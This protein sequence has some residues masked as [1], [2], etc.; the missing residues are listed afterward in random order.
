MTVVT[1]RSAEC[2]DCHTQIEQEKVG[3]I[4]LPL[5]CAA[6][7]EKIAAKARDLTKSFIDTKAEHVRRNALAG[8]NVSPDV[9][10]GRLTLD[11]LAKLYAETRIN[12]GVPVYR[13][14]EIVTLVKDFVS[15]PTLLRSV[16]MKSILILE[17]DPG[18]GKTWLLEAAIGHVVREL[19]RS[20]VFVS[21]L[22]LWAQIKG[23]DDREKSEAQVM[24]DLTNCAVLGIDDIARK[25]SPTEWEIAMLLQIIDTR[26]R[27][28][29]PTLISSNYDADGLF[30]LWSDGS[31]GRKTQNVRLLCD[32]LADKKAAITISLNGRSLRRERV[33]I[34]PKGVA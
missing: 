15:I 21:P 11:N 24:A 13:Y 34:D 9:A 20:A 16:G 6:C 8:A 33:G 29:R 25:T 18:T 30:K 27:Q 4:W 31:D 3:P 23:A 19:C 32:R 22:E 26:Y 12:G 10:S 7:D 1:T 5:R 2:L 28:N 17:G 14:T